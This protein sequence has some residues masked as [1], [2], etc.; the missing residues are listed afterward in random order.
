[1]LS[2]AVETRRQLEEEKW[3]SEDKIDEILNICLHYC[4]DPNHLRV[5]HYFLKTQ[6]LIYIPSIELH[7]R[8]EELY[9][10]THWR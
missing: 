2:T 9:R 8:P 5:R 6:I 7:E 10:R 1:M 4:Q 3:L